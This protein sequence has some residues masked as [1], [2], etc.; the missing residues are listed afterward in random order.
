M[1]RKHPRF[2]NAGRANGNAGDLPLVAP[3]PAL[4]GEPGVRDATCT[5]AELIDRGKKRQA[6][7]TFETDAGEFGRMWFEIPDCVT[8]TCRYVRAVA[9]ALGRSLRAGEPIHPGS[10]FPERRFRVQV[11]YR[12]TE[13]PRGKGRAGDDLARRKKDEA[14]FLRVIEILELLA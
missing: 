10:V 6:L 3:P 8:P 4:S 12:R 2:L 14:D 11:G 7:L 9:C 13:L 5:R 1:D